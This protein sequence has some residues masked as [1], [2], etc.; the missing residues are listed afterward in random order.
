[1]MMIKLLTATTL[2]SGLR[3]V[4]ANGNLRGQENSAF[5]VPSKKN[6]NLETLSSKSHRSLDDSTFCCTI[7]F[8]DCFDGSFWYVGVIN[9]ARIL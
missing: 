3:S 6:D 7:N 4:H 1:M 5:I 2:A 9:T 8:Q